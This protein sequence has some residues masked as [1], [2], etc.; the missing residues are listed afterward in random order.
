MGA[1]EFAALLYLLLWDGFEIL[2]DS[3]FS[4]E[5]SMDSCL[6]ILAKIYYVHM[7]GYICILLCERIVI[8]ISSSFA[9][10]RCLNSLSLMRTTEQYRQW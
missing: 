10:R 4:K 3:H 8:D 6:C 2:L 1:R 5:S 9:S 7:Y